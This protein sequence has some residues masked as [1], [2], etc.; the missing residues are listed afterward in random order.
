MSA[1]GSS[2]RP[3]SRSEPL[4]FETAEADPRGTTSL[5][6]ASCARCSAPITAAYY[7]VNRA[8]VC[9]SCRAALVDPQG[10][11]WRRAASA[12]G[13]GALAA[14]G[15]SILYFAVAAI[16][17]REF[18]LVAIVVGYMVGK[19]VRR[20]SRARGGWAYQTMA[21][22]LTYL[23]IVT[24]Y[25]PLLAKEFQ[26]MPAR[27]ARHVAGRERPADTLAA[28]PNDS[29]A[30]VGSADSNTVA[31]A[32][33]DSGFPVAQA[34]A[35]TSGRPAASAR[36]HL[37]FGTF[38]LGL[39]ALV[40]LAVIVPIAAGFSNLIGLLIIGIAVFEAW[41]LNRRSPLQV[42][43]PYRLGGVSDGSAAA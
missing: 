29:T 40:L 4:Q 17:G 14:L 2:P 28:A 37:G 3:D 12:L 11:R 16:T 26:N 43:G 9:P 25:I 20:G 41:N 33:A 7:E 23:A 21:V 10:S 35:P 42:T 13:W 15:G 19:G 1:D 32:P 27:T 8:I 24:S 18:G 39:G 30:Q 5:T 22:A 36:A 31:A 34:G 38:V 6:S